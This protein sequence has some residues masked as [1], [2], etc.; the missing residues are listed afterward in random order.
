LKKVSPW[1]A[2]C[3]TALLAG[4]LEFIAIR[5]A[6]GFIAF[7]NAL[8]LLLGIRAETPARIRIRPAIRMAGIGLAKFIPS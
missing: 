8:G 1:S 6:R 3:W 4:V 7:D 5:I 2:S